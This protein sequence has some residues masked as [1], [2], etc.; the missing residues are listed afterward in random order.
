MTIQKK[1]KLIRVQQEV[2][3]L[4]NEGQVMV[5]DKNNMAT[6]LNQ[7]IAPQTRYFLTKKRYVT[8]KDN[9]KPVE[10]KG[11]GYII[12][13]RG[14]KALATNNPTKKQSNYTSK[15]KEKNCLGCRTVKPI[16]DFVTIYGFSNPR[17]KYCKSCFLEKQRKHAISLM[18]GRDFCLYCGVK[19]EKAYDWTAEGK[20]DH[21]YLHLDHMDPIS[22]GGEYSERNTVYCCVS[23]NI[24]KGDKLFIEWLEELEPK[25]RELSRN[26]YVKKHGKKPE[27]FEPSANKTM[28]RIDLSDVFKK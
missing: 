11:N 7:N 26:I 16:K 10:T 2:L 17:G 4:L 14:R 24:K 5:I 28:I 15:K 19:I 9:S 12:T 27:E 21:T 8:R 1:R 6:I 20:S 13:E 23:C 25:Y 18:E 22:L 3:Q